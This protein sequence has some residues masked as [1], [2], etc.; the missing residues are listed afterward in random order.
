MVAISG[1]FYLCHMPTFKNVIVQKKA[2]KGLKWS[3][4]FEKQIARDGSDTH[5]NQKGDR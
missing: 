4:F 1:S 3:V 5:P 2:G